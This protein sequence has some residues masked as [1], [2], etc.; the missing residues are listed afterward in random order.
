MQVAS[1]VL[2]QQKGSTPQSAAV[3]E[4]QPES[5]A[6]PATQWLREQDVPQD[7]PDASTSASREPTC[8]GLVVS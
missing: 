1:Q 7:T 5:K 2:L 4:S 6:G 3:H 8:F